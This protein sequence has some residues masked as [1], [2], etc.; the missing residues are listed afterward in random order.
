MRCYPTAAPHANYQ[1]RQCFLLG[2][3]TAEERN[4][5]RRIYKQAANGEDS[6]QAKITDR[7]M[8]GGCVQLVASGPPVPQDSYE[9]G[10]TQTINF[11]HPLD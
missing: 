6:R 5:T 2:L 7:D 11:K 8:Q 4:R 3:N 10:L 9:H 1:G